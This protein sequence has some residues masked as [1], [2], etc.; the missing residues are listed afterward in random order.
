[1]QTLTT[2]VTLPSSRLFAT[3]RPTFA[4]AK[5]ICRGRVTSYKEYDDFRK[6]YPQY[7]LPSQPRVYYKSDWTTIHDFLGTIPFNKSESMKKYWVDVNSGVRTRKV[8]TKKTQAKKYK[9]SSNPTIQDKQM[10]LEM[11]KALGVYEQIK[12]AFR[13]LFTFEELLDIVNL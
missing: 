3:R 5:V 6:G 2:E 9:I 13:T 12:P 11:A 4:E 10:F 7:N 1:M 8:R